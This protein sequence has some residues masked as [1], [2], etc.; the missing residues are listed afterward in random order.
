MEKRWSQHQNTG[1]ESSPRTVR[2]ECKKP[3]SPSQ[4]RS[5][6]GAQIV[7][8][9]KAG[10]NAVP[11][12]QEEEKRI[13]RKKSGAKT[14]LAYEKKVNGRKKFCIYST[15][16]RARKKV[17]DRADRNAKIAKK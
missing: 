16:E 3:A 7:G 2:T 9:P 15:R 13:R 8:G 14:P 5:R 1:V 12:T 6:G 4:E 11:E 10:K 17:L